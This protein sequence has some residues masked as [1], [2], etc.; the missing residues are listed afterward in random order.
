[1]LLNYL[2]KFYQKNNNKKI[3][4]LLLY[5]SCGKPQIIIYL[6]NFLYFK[7]KFIYKFLSR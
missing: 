4:I 1:M 5:I 2:Y 7:I 3:R 6:Y